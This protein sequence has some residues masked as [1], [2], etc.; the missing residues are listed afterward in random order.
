MENLLLKIQESSFKIQNIVGIRNGGLHIS[1]FISSN[2]KTHHSEITIS[3][4]NG[5]TKRKNPKI[6][7]STFNGVTPFILIDDITDNGTTLNYFDN[8]SDFIRGYDYLVAVLHW[9]PKS[10]FVPDFYSQKTSGEWIVYPWEQC[11]G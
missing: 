10:S 3:F 1:R 11:N 2:L 9:N 4:Y 8:H 5:E 7:F 6:D